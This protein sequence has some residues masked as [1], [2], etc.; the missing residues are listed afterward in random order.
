MGIE[1]AAP[2][3]GDRNLAPVL[4]T[5]TSVGAIGRSELPPV[6][7]LLVEVTLPAINRT[8]IVEPGRPPRKSSVGSLRSADIAPMALAAPR[9]G[10][11]AGERAGTNGG[12]TKGTGARSDAMSAHVAKN[13]RRHEKSSIG[14]PDGLQDSLIF[15]PRV[16][17]CCHVSAE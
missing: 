8:E 1:R 12:L 6:A 11:P 10:R 5:E 3:V 13:V 14:G 17:R 16:H 2:Q 15:S 4:E 9:P 7:T